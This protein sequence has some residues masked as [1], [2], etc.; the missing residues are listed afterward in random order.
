[1]ASYRYRADIPARALSEIGF[2]TDVNQGEADVVVFSKPMLDDLQMAHAAKKEGARVIVDLGDDHLNHPALGPLYRDMLGVADLVVTPTKEMAERIYRVSGKVPE[3]IPDPYEQQERAPH[4]VG[5]RVLWF[6][7]KS[8]LGD[9][10]S[11]MPFLAKWD[12]HCVTGPEAGKYIEWSPETV[13]QEL[14]EANIVIIPTRKG[15]EYK[16]SNRLLNAVRAGCF[17]VAASHPAHDEFRKM[18]WVG[19]VKTGL[20]WVKAFQEDLNGL[21]EQAQA[22]VRETYSPSV[23]AA[24]WAQVL[25]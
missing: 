24:R 16:S 8:N 11:L 19:N 7:H 14:W 20:D 25:Q 4:A 15:A 1:M 12:F 23:V 18:L 22:Y 5:D 10:K 6:G 9:L 3:V 2:E 17:V 21:V 13:D